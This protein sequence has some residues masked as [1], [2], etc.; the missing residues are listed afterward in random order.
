M[1]ERGAAPACKLQQ[2]NACALRRTISI[3]SHYTLLQATAWLN[4]V[5]HVLDISRE[6]GI[7]AEVSILLLH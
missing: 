7:C 3:K 1:N 5:G 4:V 6:L 2:D